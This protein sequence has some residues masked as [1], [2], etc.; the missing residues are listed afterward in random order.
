MPVAIA[1]AA[2]RTSLL[3]CIGATP[4]LGLKRIVPEGCATV[5][6]KAEFMNPG[7][8]VKDRIARFII[9]A[10]EE[11]GQLRAGDTIL[12]VTS[13]N[14]GIAMAMVGAE[15]G[16]RVVIMM[17]KSAS[18]ERRRMIQAYGAELELIDSVLHIS[19][20]RREAEHRA[21]GNPRLFL[22]RQFENPDNPRAH[23]LTTGAEILAQAGPD[24]DAFVMGVGTGGTLMGV[25]QALRRVNRKVR[26]V[27]VEP[28]ESAVM[29]GEAPGCHGI[30]GLADG[31]IPE[32]VDMNA[33]DQVMAIRT[34]DAIE[35]AMRIAREEALFVGISA[36]ANV[37]AAIRLAQQLGPE[38]KVVTVLPDR[39]ER[40]L[41]VW[42]QRGR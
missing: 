20:A 21:N 37:L 39:G 8:S 31:F 15:K 41:S 33:I 3:Q 23:A 1:A 26:I 24:V 2:P 18:I 7:G 17:P 9:E 42:E 29:S 25:A 19:D 16:Y 27:A 22:P 36:G 38:K 5:L 28:A 40:Y 34:E 32:I 4:L 12:E 30:Q 6:A 13:G 35:M 10:A 11:R 14:T